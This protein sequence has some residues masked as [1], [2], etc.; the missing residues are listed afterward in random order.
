M[1]TG[2]DQSS[3]SENWPGS[4]SGESATS[5]QENRNQNT[6]TDRRINESGSQIYDQV[7]EEQ[8]EEISRSESVE[9]LS[10]SISKLDSVCE[11]TDNEH[12]AYKLPA[13]NVNNNNSIGR[14]EVTSPPKAQPR[15]LKNIKNFVPIHLINRSMQTSHLTEMKNKYKVIEPSFLSKLKE[16]GEIQKPIYVLYPS[17]ALPDLDF[18]KEKEENVAKMYLLPQK[19]PVAGVANKKRPFSCN[20]MEALKKKGFGHIQDWD[21]LNFLLPCEY[22]QILADVPEVA[23]QLNNKEKH[24]KQKKRPASCDYTGLLERTSSLDRATNVSSS[25]STATQ[26]SSGYR[27]SSTMLLTDSQSSPA[28]QT[29]L[30]PL[31]VYRYDSVTSSEASLMASER[32][33]SITTTAAP[34]LPKR[35]VSVNHDQ[36]KTENIPPRPPLPR[37]ILR[38]GLEKRN[39]PSQKRYSMI[40]K[41]NDKVYDE[42]VYK[43][44]SLQEPY[45]LQRNKRL[46]ETEDEGVDAGT[47]S[48][49]LEEQVEKTEFLKPP[50]NMNVNFL[51]NISMDELAQLEEF[52][53]LSGISS[54]E[55]E[56]LDEEGLTQLR[57]YVSKFLALKINQE[58]GEHFGGKKNVSFAEKVKVLPKQLAPNNSPNVS[59]FGHQRNNYQT[60]TLVDMPICEESEG[61][62]ENCASPQRTP[63][64][65]SYDLAQKRSLISA[66]TEAVEQLIHHFSPATNQS[67]LN[68]LGDS[69]LNPACAKLALSTLCPALYAV[70]SDG[71]KP[72]LQTSFGDIQNSVWQVVETSSQQG[73]LT[74]ALHE[75]VMRINSEDVITEGLVK[76]NA[77]VFGLLNTRSLDA[78]ASYLR[79]RESVLRKH[80]DPDALLL[81]S[82]TGG[83]TVRSLVDTLIASL[84]PLALLPFQFDLLFEYRQL[85]LSLKRMD[86]YQQLLSPTKHSPSPNL[87]KQW[88]N[89]LVLS[90]ASNRS[91]SESEEVSTATTVKN[92]MM[93]SKAEPDIITSS[94]SR[95]AENRPRSCVDPGVFSKPNFRLG[96]DVTSI[97]KKRWSGISLS[98]KLYQVYDRLACEDDE[99]YTDSLENPLPNATH[100]SPMDEKSKNA[101][102]DSRAT[103]QEDGPESLDSNISDDKPLNARRFKKL[104]RKWETLSGKE[105]SASNSPPAS[106]THA[107]KSRI[108]RLLSSPVKPSGIPV[109]VSSAKKSNL[110]SPNGKKSVMGV[111]RTPSANNLVRNT[112]NNK[113]SGLSTRY[114][115]SN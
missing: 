3:A 104:Q 78:W 76:F 102:N 25:S 13:F 45:F 110:P 12:G 43:R 1:S 44:R 65:N 36:T 75:L 92:A 51:S 28:A 61:S 93:D 5:D 112:N 9:Q 58:G 91:N 31:F 42:V 79:T 14:E 108:P 84:Q 10:E 8:D 107:V 59:A 86:S 20:D 37:G 115:Q 98:S 74:K 103:L 73:P 49:S 35:S 95:N 34:P 67:E 72:S 6:S 46:S 70:L 66:V 87:L 99:E 27:G 94:K 71:L 39:D 113:K 54:S 105:S 90:S 17:Y 55:G 50:P 114:E 32:Q 33:R 57:S 89:K 41:D 85:H 29:N 23:Q 18:L 48:S 111:T 97:A 30:N 81:L 16:E 4:Q 47:S 106:P 60:K 83:A 40:I 7:I 82:H 69:S 80:Y 96:E 53:K 11:S 100:T 63:N 88:N 38:K 56:E 24:V 19:A 101:T 21:S 109:P 52:L 62:P 68:N 22:K 2:M 26:P 64:K 77:F 15:R